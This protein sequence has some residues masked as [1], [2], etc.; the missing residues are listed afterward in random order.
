VEDGIGA[1]TTVKGLIGREGSLG[2]RVWVLD[3]QHSGNFKVFS[4]DLVVVVLTSVSSMIRAS[5][6]DSL[7]MQKPSSKLST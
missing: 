1:A 3:S 7:A 6:K 2:L 4:L 5:S